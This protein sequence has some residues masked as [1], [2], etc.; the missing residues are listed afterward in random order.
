MKHQNKWKKM[1]QD[2]YKLEESF[3]RVNEGK[4]ELCFGTDA[5]QMTTN[6]YWNIITKTMKIAIN[7][8]EFYLSKIIYFC[9]VLSY[10]NLLIVFHHRLCVTFIFTFYWVKF[11]V[12]EANVLMWVKYDMQLIFPLNTRFKS[13]K[14][15]VWVKAI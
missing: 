13:V 7:V 1:C 3:P 8:R 10:T 2:R 14:T 5:L 6:S 15:G 12:I 11:S 4:N 9:C